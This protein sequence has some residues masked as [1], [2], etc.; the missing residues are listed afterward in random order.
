MRK[1]LVVLLVLLLGG[2]FVADLL[3]KRRAETE[4]AK[5]VAANYRLVKQPSVDIGGFPFLSQAI[6]G[7]YDQISVGIGDYTQ[8]GVTVRD[9]NIRLDDLNAPLGDLVNGNRSNITART[10]TASAVIP[11]SYVQQATAARGVTRVAHN[12]GN[13][14]LEGVFPFMGV[15]A[16]VTVI[17]SLKPTRAGVVVTPQSVSTSGVQIPIALVQ[18]QLTYTIPLTGLPMGSRLT[19]VEPTDSGI[20]ITGQADNV[21]LENV[22]VT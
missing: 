17:V 12:S 15:Q 5:E 16:P 6:G 3:V 7:T 22:P 19:K 9:V 18:Q 11:Y 10:A 1:F 2:L 20:K 21:N 13:L 8:Q 14:Q 4:I